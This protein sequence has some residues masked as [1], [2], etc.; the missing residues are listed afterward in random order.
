MAI[1]PE[2]GWDTV[3]EQVKPDEFQEAKRKRQT[4]DPL[5]GKISATELK[6]NICRI[7]NL[8]SKFGFKD[9]LQF[10]PDDCQEEA[11]GLMA[12]VNR[13]PQSRIVLRLIGPLAA[14]A[15]AVEKVQVLVERRNAKLANNVQPT[16]AVPEPVGN[17]RTA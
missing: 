4:A 16:G 11:D 8:L 14:I 12:L 6:G 10:T 1:S 9:D 3:F 7:Y 2:G 15:A 13:W 5:E 17:N